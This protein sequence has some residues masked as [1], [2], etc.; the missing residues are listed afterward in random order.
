MKADRG[1]H[2]RLVDRLI[3]ELASKPYVNVIYANL[4][5]KKGEYDVLTQQGNPNNPNDVHYVYYE[6]KSNDTY[7]ARCK[8]DHQLK[9]GTL[10]WSKVTGN[11]TYGVYYTPTKVS[12]FA[13][14]GNRR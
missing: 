4:E 9:R 1:T 12:V 14:N 7:K 6:V 3:K 13:K 5:Y 11:D 10:H 8:A 2:N